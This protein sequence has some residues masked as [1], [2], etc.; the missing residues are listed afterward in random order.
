MFKFVIYQIKLLYIKL[1]IR[2]KKN[3]CL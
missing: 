1:K 2:Q 3:Y